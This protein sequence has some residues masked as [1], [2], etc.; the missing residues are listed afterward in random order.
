MPRPR[1]KRFVSFCPRAD[2]FKPRG[3]PMHMLKII[4]L[5]H[6][7]SEA[8]R[9]KNLENLDQVNCAKKM[10]TSQST[11]NRILNSAYRKLSDAVINGKVIKIVKD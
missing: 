4:E 8:L 5:T 10:K 9:L 1:L 11:F 3:I 7:E 6:E 2:Y